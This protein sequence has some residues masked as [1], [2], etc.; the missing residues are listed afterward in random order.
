MTWNGSAIT[1]PV[2]I[3]WD[4]LPLA[5]HTATVGD[6]NSAGALV[7]RSDQGTPTWFVPLSRTVPLVATLINSPQDFVQAKSSGKTRLFRGKDVEDISN[8]L[9]NAVFFCKY[10]LVEHNFIT[11]V[12]RDLG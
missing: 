4:E 7:C 8:R 10:N 11:L 6:V 9:L 2:L 5:R 1:G 3:F 12:N